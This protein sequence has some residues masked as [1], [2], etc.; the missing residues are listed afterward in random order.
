MWCVWALAPI[1]WRM[2]PPAMS[3]VPLL[4]GDT[5]PSNDSL[6]AYVL[7][8]FLLLALALSR[9]SFP[10]SAIHKPQP[11]KVGKSHHDPFRLLLPLLLL[12]PGILYSNTLSFAGTTR[13]WHEYGDDDDG[14]RTAM[15]TSVRHDHSARP[16]R[17][18]E[19]HIASFCMPSDLTL[20]S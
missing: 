1:R 7:N 10:H 8:A 6:F 2:A 12:R 3:E 17:K 18:T 5:F 11:D 15:G 9:S 20:I 19:W 4:P 16:G 14:C 13:S